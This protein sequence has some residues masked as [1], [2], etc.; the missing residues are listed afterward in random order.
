MIVNRYEGIVVE[1]LRIQDMPRNRCLSKSIADVGWGMLRSALT[2]M[3]SLS[4]GVTA[5]VDPR[6]TSQ[7]CSRCGARVKKNLSVRV[8]VCPMCGLV[9]DGDVNAAR[10]V[11]KRGLEIG[12]GPPE[13]TPGGEEATTLLSV[14]VQAVS[15]KQEAHDLSHG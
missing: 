14:W 10:N 7:T 4:E 9:L 15:V 12:R 6:G 3:A 1:D 2:Y 13:Y 11:L 5:F 8:H